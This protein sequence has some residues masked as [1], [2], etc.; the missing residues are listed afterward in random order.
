METFKQRLKVSF[1]HVIIFLI[2]YIPYNFIANSAL[3]DN[4]V[5][6]LVGIAGLIYGFIIN[7][8]IVNERSK[9]DRT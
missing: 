8:Y 4:K 6:M 2:I 9:K 1:I 7:P 3:I 5:L